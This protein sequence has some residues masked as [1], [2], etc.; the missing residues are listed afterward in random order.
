MRRL[1][2]RT[3]LRTNCDTVVPRVSRVAP[4][5]PHGAHQENVKSYPYVKRQRPDWS[6]RLPQ[7]LVIPKVMTLATLDDVR[8]L[9]RH[10][11]KDRR[12]MST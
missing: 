6:R 3:A 12:E 1:T 11:P 8:K 9:M 10:L 2:A 7:P 4:Q 5:Q